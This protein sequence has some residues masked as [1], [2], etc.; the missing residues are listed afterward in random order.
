MMQI[1]FEEGVIGRHARNARAPRELHARVV[2]DERRMDV[3]E[4]ERFARAGPRAAS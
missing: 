1:L 2:R 3:N 4:I